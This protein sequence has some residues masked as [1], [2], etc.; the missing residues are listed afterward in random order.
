[1]T[2]QLVQ[3]GLNLA[4]LAAIFIPLELTWSGHRVWRRPA[5]T[6]DL[7]FM[8]GQ[9]ALFLPVVAFLLGAWAAWVGEFAALDAI[10]RPFAQLPGVLR[11]LIAMV[12]GDFLMYWGHRAQ[13]SWEP[14]WRFHAVHHTSEDVDWLAAF[15]E[16]PLDGLYTQA[17]MNLPALIL[18]VSL[19]PWLGLIAFR[20]V[21]AILIHSRARIPLGPL[22][23]LLGSPDFHRAHHAPNP[24]VGHYANL[25]PYLDVLFGTHGPTGE[26]PQTGVTEPHPRGWLGLLVWPFVRR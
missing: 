3:I 24:H 16:H 2:A 18:G 1:M 7:L 5:W 23:W 11:V 6:T 14:L 15:R 4:W 20:G 12:L 25:A 19:G 22:K 13:H 8:I 26:P 21:W 9:A 10:R 17:L